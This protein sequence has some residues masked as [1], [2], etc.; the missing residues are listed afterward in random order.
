[1]TGLIHNAAPTT[2]EEIL[3]PDWLGWILQAPVTSVEEVETQTTVSTK[4]RMRVHLGGGADPTVRRLCVKAVVELKPLPEFYARI[5]RTEAHF[6]RDVVTGVGINHP[7]LVYAGIDE[8]TGHGLILMEDV[9]AAGATF[10][11]ALS[12]Y[13]YDQACS[14]LDQIAKLHAAHWRGAGLDAFPWIENRLA[15]MAAHPWRTDEELTRLVNDGRFDGLDASVRDI[16]R[17]HA[18]LRALH[19]VSAAQPEA[20]VHGDAHAGNLYEQDGAIALV[21]WQ[22]VQRANWALD[23]AYHVAAALSIDDRRAYERD[24]L[25]HYLSRLAG[26]GVDAPSPD[27]ALQAYRRSMVYGLYLWAITRKV[28]RPILVELAQRL[29]TAVTDLE[30]FAALD[31]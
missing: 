21:D 26:Y 1:M 22:L 5:S 27:A 7:S 15:G 8:G 23:V 10:L 12:P 28:P 19:S 31:V 14:S 18:G 16:D 2:L 30:S 13:T 4:T 17:L 20:L 3:S 6:Y 24:L 11:T 25:G 29:G 9:Q